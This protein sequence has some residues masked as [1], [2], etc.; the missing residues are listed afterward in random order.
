[1]NSRT[2]SVS[3][4]ARL[5]RMNRFFQ[6]PMFWIIVWLN[7]NNINSSHLKIFTKP[8]TA[9]NLLHIWFVKSVQDPM[10]ISV[11]P[12]YWISERMK[13]VL[14]SPT[15]LLIKAYAMLSLHKTPFPRRL[16]RYWC[17]INWKMPQFAHKQCYLWSLW[18]KLL[19]KGKR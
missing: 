5:S 4:S 15:G 10:I 13:T 17:S 19:F 14:Q 16:G 1:M 2:Y 6:W 8:R 11:S 9:L 12:K 18:T 3:S 7:N